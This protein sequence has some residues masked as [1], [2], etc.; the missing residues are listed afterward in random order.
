L[1]AAGGGYGSGATP[2]TSVTSDST[3]SFK[4]SYSCS[5]ASPVIYV[6]ALGGTAGS[7][8]Y[9]LQIGL[10]T[11]AGPCGSLS[12]SPSIAI[13][14]LTTVAGEWALAPFIDPTGQIVGAPST[15]AIAFLNSVNLANSNLVDVTSGGL[16]PFL[17]TL[18]P[19]CTGSS[20]MPNCLTI[21]KI[22]TLADMLAA[23][24]G[25]TG[26]S[27]AQCTSLFNST[28][29]PLSATTLQAAHTMAAIALNVRVDKL[30][31]LVTAQTPPPFEPILA[32]AP[33][34]L[35]ISLNYTG[36]G[37][38]SPAGVAIDGP[39]NA[40]ITNK[41]GNSVSEFNPLGTPFPASP[42]T[43]GGLKEPQGIALDQ[44][45]NVW[46]ANNSGNS[47]TELPS[48]K[49]GAPVNFTGGGLNTPA[50]AGVDQLGI[51]WITNM[52][53][54]TVTALCGATLTNCPT[55]LHTGSPISPSTG[56]AGGG[57]ATPIS[58]GF[59]TNANVWVANFG[60]GGSITE[61]CGSAR[62]GCGRNVHT[63]S[64]LSSSSGFTQPGIDAPLGLAVDAADNI[65]MVNSGGSDVTIF[66][67][68]LSAA[69]YSPALGGGL[70]FPTAIA[71]DGAGN[72]WICNEQSSS[73][74]NGGKGT[75]SALFGNSPT[76][77]PPFDA[78]SGSPI[79]PASGFIGVGIDQPSAIAVDGS[80]NVWIASAANNSLTVFVGAA[81]PVH[82]P[83]NGTPLR[84]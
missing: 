6:T 57:L 35:L 30:F 36:G 7:G 3:G 32:D 26:P 82:T 24:V 18:A 41:N 39:G 16:A 37:L 73:T 22:N 84:P 52:G 81:T 25:S 69:A 1:W 5:A 70:D 80:G 48:G 65:W 33:V 60:L 12:S 67:P 66:A 62:V 56:F 53:G 27:S 4:L 58:I 46:I 40:W 9:N 78:S 15:D 2:L 38:N 42:Y 47:V 79:S 83:I 51:V 63:G 50:G 71:L 23:C 45:E 49:P 34:G 55:G 19:S 72:A 28:Q 29:N 10:M 61:L 44:P 54:D 13:N 77:T 64:P 59:D 31:E 14:E 68:S 17:S 8:E 76:N 43:G 11:V 21:E 20:S 75:V 74:V